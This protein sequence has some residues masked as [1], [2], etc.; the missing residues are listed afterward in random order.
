MRRLAAERFDHAQRVRAQA[1]P[2]RHL[3][4]DATCQDLTAGSVDYFPL[5][6]NSP[7]TVEC[8]FGAERHPYL[9]SVLCPTSIM[10]PSGS[11]M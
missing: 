3:S 10:Y 9:R 2:V 1:D 5:S 8:F 4:G 6:R 7:W 11:R